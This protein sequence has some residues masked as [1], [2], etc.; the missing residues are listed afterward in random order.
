MTEVEE[1]LISESLVE[2]GLPDHDFEPED[3]MTKALVGNV[4][5]RRRRVLSRGRNEFRTGKGLMFEGQRL[6]G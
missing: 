6:G 5:I 3:R 1:N 2:E 4:T